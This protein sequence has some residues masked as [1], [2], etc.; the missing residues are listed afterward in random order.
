[1]A[2]TGGGRIAA[3]SFIK[4]GGN[5]ERKE[6]QGAKDAPARGMR[7]ELVENIRKIPDTILHYLC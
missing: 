5:Y 3:C 1:M 6:K 4:D 7:I 2:E